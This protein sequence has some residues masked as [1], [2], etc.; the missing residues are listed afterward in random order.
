VTAGVADQAKDPPRHSPYDQGGDGLPV[1]VVSSTRSLT[2]TGRSS[3][4]QIKNSRT[5][6]PREKNH[7]LIDDLVGGDC[8]QPEK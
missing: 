3:I 8:A 1:D 4:L 6:M 7:C 2:P 5:L